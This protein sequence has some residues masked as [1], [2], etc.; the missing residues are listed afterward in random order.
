MALSR[1]RRQP[2]EK[3]DAYTG[4]TG[5]KAGRHHQQEKEGGEENAKGEVDLKRAKKR[6]RQNSVQDKT[7]ENQQQQRKI[8]NIGGKEEER[9]CLSL[10]RGNRG[11]LYSE[12]VRETRRKSTDYVFDLG[13]TGNLIG[14]QRR[15][16]DTV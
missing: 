13:C 15:G 10:A 12:A 6:R 1:V 4:G 14:G 2:S 3:G 16:E 8:L 9:R 5:A 7:E 11:G